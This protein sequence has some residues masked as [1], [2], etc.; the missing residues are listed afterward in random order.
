MR[1]VN[2]TRDLRCLRPMHWRMPTAPNNTNA[3]NGTHPRE[4]PHG[5]VGG[6]HLSNSLPWCSLAVEQEET[7]R[8]NETPIKFADNDGRIDDMAKCRETTSFVSPP[9]QNE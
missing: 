6:G 1:K 3:G 5:I 2:V 9:S 8:K 7:D 4:R